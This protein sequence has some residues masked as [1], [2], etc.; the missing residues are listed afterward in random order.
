M[1]RNKSEK[2]VPVDLQAPEVQ[3]Y[4]DAYL[5]ARGRRFVGLFPPN[6]HLR[7]QKERRRTAAWL[8]LTEPQKVVV[9]QLGMKERMRLFNGA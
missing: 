6:R 3:E 5:D 9:R 4:L 2:L 7:E 1:A 8:V